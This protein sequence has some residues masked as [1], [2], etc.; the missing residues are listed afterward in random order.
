MI[1]CV[2]GK[3][4]VPSSTPLVRRIARK[5]A[6]L[7]PQSA[8]RR[9]AHYR[10]GYAQEG[11]RFDFREQAGPG[12]PVAT[13]DDRIHLH[14]TAAFMPDLRFHFVENGQS[15]DEIGA[16]VDATASLPSNALLYD[17]GAHRGLFS[18]VHCALGSKRRAVLFEPSIS[19]SN[20]ARALLALNGLDTRAEVRVRGVGDRAGTRLIAEDALGFAGPADDQDADAVPIE[21]TTIDAEWRRTGDAPAVVKIDVEG[22]EGEVIRGAAVLLR[23]VRPLLF[24][25]LHLDVLEGRGEAVDAMLSQLTSCGYRFKEPDGRRRS[26]RAIRDSLRAIVRIVAYQ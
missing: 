16:F 19:L 7:L 4:Q 25:E 6:R 22:A 10:F 5:A 20:D 13:I 18:L 14:A 15:R 23:D 8:R 11:R 1:Q 9:L 2:R 21:F 3:E 26:A 17:V 24:L 12:G